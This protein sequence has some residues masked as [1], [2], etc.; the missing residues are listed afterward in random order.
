MVGLIKK[1]ETGDI[2]YCFSL[3]QSEMDGFIINSFYN[4]EELDL[5]FDKIKNIIKNGKVVPGQLMLVSVENR[6]IT[7][8]IPFVFGEDIDRISSFLESFDQNFDDRNCGEDI[9]NISREYLQKDN[10]NDQ[11][12]WLINNARGIKKLIDNYSSS[13]KKEKQLIYSNN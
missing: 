6:T 1:F 2:Y 8:E 10:I 3:T 7:G 5:Y 4:K 12:T 11:R 13:I 9:V